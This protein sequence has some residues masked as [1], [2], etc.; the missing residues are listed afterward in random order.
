MRSDKRT[1]DALRVLA[2]VGT[3]ESRARAA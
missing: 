2:E 3:K 1:M